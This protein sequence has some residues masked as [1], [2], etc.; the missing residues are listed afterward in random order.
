MAQIHN[1]GIP[2]VGILDRLTPE[3]ADFSFVSST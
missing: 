2:T 1:D 3:K